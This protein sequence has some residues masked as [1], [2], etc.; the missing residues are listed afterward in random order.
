METPLSTTSMFVN[1]I[2]NPTSVFDSIKLKTSFM[3][4]I[5]V[6]IILTLIMFYTYFHMVDPAW[7]VDHMISLNTKDLAPDQI[8]GMRKFMTVDR[9]MPVILVGAVIAPIIV[10]LLQAL[11]LMVVGNI[12]NMDVS[13]G[14]WFSLSAWS[15]VP[16]IFL[17]ILI[18]ISF[19]IEDVS[20]LPMELMNPLNFASLFG[21]EGP[22]KLYT[23]LA[24]IS[25]V[26]FLSLYLVAAGFKHWSN[27]SWTSSV[28]LVSIP[29]VLLWLAQIF[30]F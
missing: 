20:Q 11:Y 12:K 26:N 1:I 30:V 3:A 29:Y 2:T 8:E 16:A 5:I 23:T 22:G 4:P 9:M 15:L 19:A 21:I 14:E 25:I 24:G 13:Y 6:A 18:L 17:S 10:L 7:F 27:G 28:I